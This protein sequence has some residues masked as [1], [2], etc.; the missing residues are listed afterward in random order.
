MVGEGMLT[1]LRLSCSAMRCSLAFSWLFLFFNRVSGT[2]IWSCVG[3]VLQGGNRVSHGPQGG[4]VAESELQHMARHSQ[5][6]CNG[7]KLDE[8]VL[9]SEKRM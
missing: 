2:R 5:T 9:I 4:K 6:G 1:F 3:T 8:M 7:G